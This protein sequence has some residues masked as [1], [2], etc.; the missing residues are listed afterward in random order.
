MNSIKIRCLFF[1]LL[2]LFASCS[3]GNGHD[4][5]GENNEH[6]NQDSIAFSTTHHY[7]IGYNFVLIAD[8]MQLFTTPEGVSLNLDYAP[9][10][11]IIRSNE[12]FVITEIYHVPVVDS[13]I[14][15]SIW[16]RVGS[17]G[18]PLGWVSEGELLNKAA[19]VD[20]ISLLIFYVRHHDKFILALSFIIIL[21]IAIYIIVA[22]KKIA[23]FNKQRVVSYYSIAFLLSITAAGVV[24]SIL[25]DKH[26]D[27]WQDFYFHPTLN[28]LGLQKMLAL[29]LSTI[30]LSIILWLASIFDLIAKTSPIKTARTILCYTIAGFTIYTLLTSALTFLLN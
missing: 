16:L 22:E 30:W 14:T 19:P 5:V 26:S 20:P 7:N 18:I 10:S 13:T 29:Y 2:Y 8:S 11:A 9:D 24:Y 17:D 27:L 4:Y 23:K 25:T 1:A 6:N 28:P 15:D 12:D 3:V 21:A